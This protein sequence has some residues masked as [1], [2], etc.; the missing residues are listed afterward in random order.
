MMTAIIR[1]SGGLCALA[2]VLGLAGLS[3][4]QPVVR[5][6]GTIVSIADDA[7]S[8]V[9]AEVGPWQLR[10]GAT[11]L[12]RRTIWLAP[13]TAYAIVARAETAPSGFPGDFVE[14]RIGPES[15]YLDDYVT[16]ECRIEGQRLVARKVTVIEVARTA[17][18]ATPG[19]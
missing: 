5:H 16:V 11:V 13:D 6:S 9:L 1:P 15:V 14:R 12:T 2:L 17:A 4:A 7:R 10:D 3:A 8:F 19:R 18:A